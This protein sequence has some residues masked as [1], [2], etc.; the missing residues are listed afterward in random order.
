MS[1]Q[2]SVHALKIELMPHWQVKHSD[3]EDVY[4]SHIKIWSCSK[5]Q[6]PKDNRH[7]N[8]QQQRFY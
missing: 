7:S 1:E 6:Q 3:L 5:E 8:E 4:E 2:C